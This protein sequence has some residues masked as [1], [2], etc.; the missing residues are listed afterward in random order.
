MRARLAGVPIYIRRPRRW[1]KADPV[2]RRGAATARKLFRSIH[3]HP[4]H[5]SRTATAGNPT[6]GEQHLSSRSLLIVPSATM[7]TS[8]VPDPVQEVLHP[9]KSEPNIAEERKSNWKSTASATAKLVLRG[10]RDSAD[11][12]P[13]LKSVAGGLCYILDN[14]EV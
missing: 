6:V 7:I 8:T 3:P 4:C 13:P 5:R 14:C 9:N 2:E 1:R 11:A 10:V 12:F